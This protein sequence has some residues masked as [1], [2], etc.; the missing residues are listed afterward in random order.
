MLSLLLRAASR[1]C[2]SNNQTRLAS[3]LVLQAV[4]HKRG[5]TTGYGSR[6]YLLLPPTATLEQVK[7]DPKVSIASLFAHKNIIF[8][9][10]VNDSFDMIEACSP[11][12]QAALHDA[13]D[14][15]EQPQAVASLAGLCNFVENCLE[16]EDPILKELDS[17]SLEAC[18]AIAT[19]IPRAGHSMVGFGTFRDGQ[20]GWEILAKEFVNRNLSQEANLY[21]TQGGELVRVE[22]L[23]DDS[24]AYM[25]TAGGAMSRLFFV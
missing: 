8:G 14:V 6:E 9:A 20:D 4:V 23:A 1:S 7:V 3:S 22:H 24:E 17:L 19:G 11:L 12:L 16:Q 5:D 15:G 2:S 21:K 10:K 25:K 13:A 18:T